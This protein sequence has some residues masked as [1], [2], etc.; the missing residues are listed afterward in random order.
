MDSW[1]LVYFP[2]CIINMDGYG[3]Y[4]DGEQKA[5][6]PVKGVYTPEIE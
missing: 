4:G 5:I 6:S 1:D 2:T 3:W